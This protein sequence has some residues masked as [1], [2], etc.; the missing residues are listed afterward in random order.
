MKK[1]KILVLVGLALMA[2]S[3][4]KADEESS[5]GDKEKTVYL[6]GI[7]RDKQDVSDKGSHLLDLDSGSDKLVRSL[8]FNLSDDEYLGKR[9]KVEGFVNTEDGVFEI[10]KI[11]VLDKSN[12]EDDKKSKDLDFQSSPLGFK[13]K[14]FSDWTVDESS[15]EVNFTSP[16]GSRVIVDRVA[17]DFIDNGEVDPLGQYLASEY[18]GM[19]DF[20]GLSRSVGADGLDAFE[21]PDD[22]YDL[23]Y[24]F[25]RKGYV[26]NYKYLKS[27]TEDDDLGSGQILS[28]FRFIGFSAEDEDSDDDAADTD[29]ID[30]DTADISFA[31]FESQPFDF[32]AAYPDDWYFSGQ[33][34]TAGAAYEYIFSPEE[35][36]SEVLIVMEVGTRIPSGAE[37]VDY[38]N[39]EIFEASSG[40]KSVFYMSDAD[41]V[42]YSVTADSDLRSVALKMIASVK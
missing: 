22:D 6:S 2:F 12:D 14:Y 31:T 1:I 37:T 30:L 38:D 26:Y 13:T 4:G 17:F 32:S 34:S 21:I 8:Y 15:S 16:K 9:L 3:C 11:Q 25:Y 35:D 7:L 42:A 20:T 40:G 10:S 36:L 33:Q 27:P 24:V 23:L 19:H 41:G 39:I 5:V 28:N 18:P 29:D